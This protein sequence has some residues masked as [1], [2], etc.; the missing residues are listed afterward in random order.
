MKKII[1]FMTALVMVMTMALSPFGGGG[2]KVQ[3]EEFNSEIR[4]TEEELL[5]SSNQDE[6]MKQSQMSMES[7]QY[8]MRIEYYKINN[9]D[10]FQGV[11]R[12][13]MDLYN[14]TMP[15]GKN[16]RAWSLQE[17]SDFSETLVPVELR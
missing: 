3:A 8:G 2:L 13:F 4:L 17:Y 11:F 15:F 16:M 6:Q 10:D 12:V 14:S 7:K 1:S 9:I 5:R